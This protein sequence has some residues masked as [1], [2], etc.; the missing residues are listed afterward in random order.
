[1]TRSC[2]FRR[3]R[4]FTLIELL[5][6]IAII[7]ILVALLLPAVQSAREAARRS[8]CKN[9][10]HQLALGIHNYNDVYGLCPLANTASDSKYRTPWGA[11][12]LPQIDQAGL[13]NLLSPGSSELMSPNTT[14][15]AVFKCPSD[16][17]A[18]LIFH[19]DGGTLT[20]TKQR[21]GA[22]NDCWPV[23]SL[24]QITDSG[25]GTAL[26]AAANYVMTSHAAVDFSMDKIVKNQGT[27]NFLLIGER[28]SKGQP[29]TW[30]GKFSGYVGNPAYAGWPQT[31]VVVGSTDQCAASSTSTGPNTSGLTTLGSFVTRFNASPASA[32]SEHNGGCHF[33]MADGSVRFIADTIDAE[34]QT[35]IAR[36]GKAGAIGEF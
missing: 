1:M 10:L 27:S 22:S 2:S 9:N 23:R 12:I 29:T 31:T 34:T 26:C 35:K 17:N 33:S 25:T 6:V 3:A 18:D 4:A 5:V 7:A 14:S 32:S 20:W 11:A 36:L 21:Q 8:Q 15:I 24:S 16:P 13:F 28:Q 19:S 30:L